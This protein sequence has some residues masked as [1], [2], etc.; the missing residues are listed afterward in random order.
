MITAKET[1]VAGSLEKSCT[2]IAFINQFTPQPTFIF[3]Q[4]WLARRK[5]IKLNKKKNKMHNL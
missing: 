5:E 3:P 1:F 2:K 4:D